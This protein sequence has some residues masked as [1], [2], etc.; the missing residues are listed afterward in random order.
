MSATNS[1]DTNKGIIAWFARNHVAAN[2][3]MCVI[4]LTGIFS[5]MTI[6]TQMMPDVQIN[7]VN[8][9]IAFP[10]AAP[11]EVESGVVS[12]IEEA[13]RDVEGIDEMRSF[14][15]EGFGRVRLDI[16][17]NY[18][19]LAILDEVKIAVDRISQLPRVHRKT[20]HLPQSASA[21]RYS[22][23]DI[24]QPERSPNEGTGGNDSR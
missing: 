5:A 6:R 10:G 13:V 15:N 18:D 22:H 9:D 19:V 2:L 21:T 14:S 24:R 8:V 11:G 12:R 23:S 20:C 3:L 1:F 16:Q 17:S 7:Q 4:V